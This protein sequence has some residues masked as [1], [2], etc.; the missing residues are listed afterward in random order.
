MREEL[1]LSPAEEDLY[2]S[3][4]HGLLPGQIQLHLGPIDPKLPFPIYFNLILEQ[5]KI[6]KVSTE[7]GWSHQG[8]EKL[9]EQVSPEQGCEIIRR[10]NPLCPHIFEHLFR[11][12]SGLEGLD[13]EILKA[14]R[15]FY[16]LH[17]IR[18][19]LKLLGEHRLIL[20]SEKNFEKFKSKF[21]NSKRIQ[22]RLSGL[23]VISHAQALSYGLTGPSLK[24]CQAP[25]TGDVW[26][27]LVVKLDEISNP[28]LNTAPEGTLIISR[29]AGRVRIRTPA[30]AHAGALSVFLKNADL[31]DLVLILLSLG[32]VGTEIDR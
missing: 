2:R 13:L 20:L 12:A 3:H 23:G 1:I 28:D 14:E 8:I 26:S 9:L 27:R 18:E 16:Y 25:Y 7:I 15:R 10:V 17:F 31:N 19:I 32:L 30:F 4:F 5:R 29:Q 6:I 11:I 21:L 22:K 24:A